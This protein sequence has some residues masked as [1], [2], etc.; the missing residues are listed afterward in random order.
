MSQKNSFYTTA[1]TASTTLRST[2]T[3]FYDSSR[4]MDILIAFKGDNISY[5]GALYPLNYAI[6]DSNEF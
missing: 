3:Y 2:Q 5:Y 4:S 1:T 6:Y